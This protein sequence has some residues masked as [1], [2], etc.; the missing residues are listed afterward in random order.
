MQVHAL[1]PAAAATYAVRALR[2]AGHC[3]TAGWHCV[4]VGCR[5]AP[6]VWCCPPPLY[7]AAALCTAT[8]ASISGTHSVFWRVHHAAAGAS[9]QQMRWLG[10]HFNTGATQSVR[11]RTGLRLVY[12]Y[13]CCCL[14][15]PAALA[16]VASLRQAGPPHVQDCRPM[17]AGRGVG[18]HALVRFAAWSVTAVPLYASLAGKLLSRLPGMRCNPALTILPHAREQVPPGPRPSL[19]CWPR[20]FHMFFCL[21]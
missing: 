18:M 2:C 20:P 10:E 1:W 6:A 12:H 8:S 17:G 21:C 9:S 15:P 16:G 11:H 19:D 7:M 3:L 4:T 5:C 14:P 13:A